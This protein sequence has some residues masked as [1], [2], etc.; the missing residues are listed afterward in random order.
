MY[1]SYDNLWKTLVD[2]KISKTEL[3]A[4]TGMS[5]RTLAKLSKCETVTTETLLSV[6][7]ALDCGIADIME[8]LPG[9]E[10][11][12]FFEAFK[13]NA[14][15]VEKNGL[16]CI[17]SLEYNYENYTVVKTLKSANKH[18]VIRLES[19]NILWDQLIPM[20]IRPACETTVLSKKNF[21]EKGTRGVFVVS[22]VPQRI[23]GLDEG[24]YVSSKRK[25][26][27]NSDVYVMTAAALKL[28]CPEAQE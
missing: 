12:T 23:C 14:A 25:A 10:K 15:L 28:F 7:E 24:G 21:A 27:T 8:I 11:L 17:Y 9:E 3:M 20:G 2:R 5:S 6:C 18:T 22:G 13:K 4:L 19:E 1:I 16:C 26:E